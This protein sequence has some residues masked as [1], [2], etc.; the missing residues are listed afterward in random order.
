MV[1]EE[2]LELFHNLQDVAVR[3]ARLQ[4]RKKPHIKKYHKTRE[5]HQE[6]IDKMCKYHDEHFEECDKIMKDG[7]KGYMK[8][9]CFDMRDNLDEKIFM[10]LLMHPY[11]EDSLCELFLRKKKVRSEKNISMIQAMIDSSISVYKVVDVDRLNCYVTLEDVLTSKKVTIVDERLS[12][13]GGNL[14]A[15]FFVMRI[16]TWEGI[17]FQTG[18]TMAFN[19][20]DPRIRKWIKRN[21]KRHQP[22][23]QLLELHEIYKQTLQQPDGIK[24]EMRYVK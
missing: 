10:D 12:I 9:I 15:V 20:N 16:I 14:N 21:K 7:F 5:L 13:V 23:Q 3:F 18:T 19:K 2:D 6:I 11:F 17:S 4:N 1:K 8:N 22:M 24:V